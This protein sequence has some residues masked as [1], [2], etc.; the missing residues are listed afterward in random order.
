MSEA[1]TIARPFWISTYPDA[2]SFC[3]YHKPKRKRIS[4]VTD[5]NQLTFWRPLLVLVLQSPNWYMELLLIG[6]R[7]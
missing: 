6:S 7:T 2:C 4:S 1:C 3:D 5:A